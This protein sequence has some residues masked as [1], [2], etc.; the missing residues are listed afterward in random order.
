MPNSNVIQGQED[1]I[2]NIIESKYNITNIL[3]IGMGNG[4]AS[5]LFYDAG[6]NVT[7]TG[8]N[9]DS[10]ENESIAIPEGIKILEDVNVT[11]MHQFKDNQFDAIWIAHVLEHVFDTGLALKEIKRVLKPG[12]YLFVSVPPFKHNVVG[13]HVHTGW[14]IGNLMYTLAATG[15]DL[16]EEGSFIQHGYNVFGICKKFNEEE[17][18]ELTYSNG[19]LEKLCSKKRFPKGFNAKQGFQ[20][21]IKSV[22]WTWKT[23]IDSFKEKISVVFFVPWITKGKGGTEHVG[24]QMANMMASR[25]HKVSVFTFD[26]DTDSKSQWTLDESIELIKIPESI[27]RKAEGD[28]LLKLATCEPDLIVGL[29]MNRTFFK[30][31]F[32]AKRLNVPVILSEHI[33]PRMPRRIGNFTEQERNAIFSQAE[34]IHLLTE[35]FRSTLPAFVQKNIKVIPNTVREAYHLATPGENEV[36]T[37]LAVA[38]L[39][40]RKNIHLLIEAF[41]LN[42]LYRKAIL[43]IVG[44]GSQEKSLKELAKKLGIADRVKFLGHLEDPYS[45]Y[46]SA[47]LFVIPSL[48]EG[49]PMTVLEA[50]AHGLPIIGFRNCAGVNEQILDGVNGYL[51]DKVSVETLS[52]AICNL[53]NCQGLLKEFGK[54]SLERYYNIYSEEII[55]N[56]WEAMF[57]KV[58]CKKV[59]SIDCSLEKFLDVKFLELMEKGCQLAEKSRID[60]PEVILS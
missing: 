31:V 17:N 49:L 18:I 60:V 45:E 58:A 52:E 25:G 6:Y 16:Y 33:D 10:Y 5:K 37:V 15:F 4:L 19:D 43:K 1:L 57:L 28:V 8:F 9:I 55:C 32:F 7:A 22:N 34:G 50:M 54:E 20:G 12:G 42:D 47:D 11:N 14:N 23:K 35:G 40:D 44:N 36:V 51:V 41:S 48:Y 30:Y 27:D 3:D 56:Q 13:G 53:V 59:K 46:E 24:S 38:R 26:D 39:V 2:N 29:H 21:K